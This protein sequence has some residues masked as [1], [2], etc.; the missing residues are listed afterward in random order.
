M[1]FMDRYRSYS[2]LTDEEVRADFKAQADE[3]RENELSRVELLDLTSSTADELPH[4]AVAAAISFAAKRALNHESDPLS[5]ELRDRFA[6]E[7]GIPNARVGVG[8]GA[9]GL[10]TAL[11]TALAD[12]G[13][14]ILIPWPAYRLHPVLVRT[15]GATPI[16]LEGTSGVESLISAA[17]QKESSPVLILTNPNDPD[18]RLL[19]AAEVA[20]LRD[21]LPSTTTLVVDEALVDYA[22]EDHIRAMNDL[23]ADTEGLYLVRSLSKAWGL[24]GLRVGWVLG[25]P[26]SEEIIA[27]LAP[28]LGVPMPSE[29]GALAALEEARPQ[30]DA[31]V[32]AVTRQ[33]ERLE[34]LLKGTTVELQPSA[35]NLVWARVPG[36]SSEALAAKLREAGVLVRDGSEV[37]DD[38][39]ICAAVRGD[40]TAT[41]RL[42]E[43]LVGAAAAQPRSSA[44]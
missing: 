27:R 3:R 10:L 28:V 24:S 39:H 40:E 9:S 16:P 18:G 37:G 31:R 1:G 15:V 13:D 7:A 8:A 19:S 20:S 17:E 23:V 2:E 42:A 36:I 32:K 34:S 12:S 35:S 41:D 21:G 22:G 30:R 43:G 25:G 4:P 38:E 5:S 26:E 11:V 33:R 29:A 6:A 44:D 14:Q